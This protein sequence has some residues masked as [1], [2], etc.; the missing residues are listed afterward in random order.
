MVCKIGLGD[1]ANQEKVQYWGLK[2]KNVVEFYVDFKVLN[3]DL[4][5]V[6]KNFF[7]PI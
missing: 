4:E 2:S 6:M 1:P 7:K 3:M 5:S